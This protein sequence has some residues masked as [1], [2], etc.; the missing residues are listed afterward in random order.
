MH[1]S[2]GLD[3][4]YAWMVVLGGAAVHGALL[5]LYQK[6]WCSGNLPQPWNKAIISY[7]HKKGSKT[8]VSNY[9]PISMISV[10]AKTFTKTMSRVGRLQDITADHL[11]KEQR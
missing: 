11:V 9:R 5:A 2:P 6:V 10:L 7:F 1:T 4:V 8:A 3:E